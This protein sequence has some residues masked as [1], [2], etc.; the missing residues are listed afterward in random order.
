M[1]DT[2]FV[3]VDTDV[4]SF[5]N[6]TNATGT[7]T[8]A[9]QSN[10]MFCI[11][12]RVDSEYIVKLVNLFIDDHSST[13]T[14]VPTALSFIKISGCFGGVDVGITKHDSNSNNLPSQ[15]VIR[16]YAGVNSSSTIR[17]V[18]IPNGIIVSDTRGINALVGA[19]HNIG[20]RVSLNYHYNALS[21]ECQRVVIREGEG[22]A[23]TCDSAPANFPLD[24]NITMSISGSTY[25]VSDVVTFNSSAPLIAIYNGSSS[26]VTINIDSIC[27]HQ[28][29]RALSIRNMYLQYVS[30]VYSG[31]SVAP[32]KMDSTLS[33]IS[34]GVQ[35]LTNCT[36]I[37]S[38][39][40]SVYGRLP[41]F[42]PDATPVI[43][44][45]LPTVGV[46]PNLAT[47]RML[48]PSCHYIFRSRCT[49][50]ALVIR[51]GEGIALYQ[52][53]SSAG[54]GRYTVAAVLDIT[55]VGGG[56]GSGGGE[57]SHVL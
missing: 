36:T 17:R 56:G 5:R 20:G 49:E 42:T 32:I 16:K 44:A 50:D 33:D 41:L 6:E 43:G 10:A 19:T 18:N 52:Q 53:G 57:T 38:G 30:H 26:G 46:G 1:G 27:V 45:V 7:S 51:Q 3:S 23:L 55:F 34:N 40:D 54:W 2:Y 11:Y 35:I 47:T 9:M 8:A 24:I 13:D 31:N 25:T 15:V 28:V 4:T 12:N 39:S 14:T 48:M 21:S 29:M 37:Q 22:I